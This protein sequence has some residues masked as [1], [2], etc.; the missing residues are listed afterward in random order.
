MKKKDYEITEEE[1]KTQD[2]SV[3][4]E[5]NGEVS[6]RAKLVQY[7]GDDYDDTPV[8]DES[9]KG[10]ADNFWYH[11]K[12]HVVIAA[13]VL[14]VAVI[15]IFQFIEKGKNK[16]DLS[17]MYAGPVDIYGEQADG[18]ALGDALRRPERRRRGEGLPLQFLLSERTA[19]G[20]SHRGSEEERENSR[21]RRGEEPTDAE[22]LFK[23]RLHGR[24]RRYVSRRRPV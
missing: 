10:K 11:H 19:I 20:V 21:L 18:V 13:A 2:M 12:W 6:N 23:P 17:V 1:R 22:G 24:V 9:F 7:E 3:V 16:T 5:Y 15:S 4:A 14:F 8:K